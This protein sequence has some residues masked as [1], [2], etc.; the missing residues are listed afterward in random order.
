MAELRGHHLKIF[1]KIM[2]WSECNICITN[3]WWRRLWSCSKKWDFS[4]RNTLFNNWLMFIKNRITIVFLRDSVTGHFLCFQITAA[5]SKLWVQVVTL[6]NYVNYL[7]VMLTTFL[8]C[9]VMA[10]FYFDV[11]Q[12]WRHYP[13]KLIA[14]SSVSRVLFHITNIFVT[15][16]SLVHIFL[17]L[18]LDL[19]AVLMYELSKTISYLEDLKN[20]QYFILI[21]QCN[22]M[23]MNFQQENV[24]LSADLESLLSSERL[25]DMPGFLDSQIRSPVSLPFR[26]LCWIM[27]AFRI[28]LAVTLMT[29]F[30][31]GMYKRLLWR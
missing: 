6:S 13:I 20:F 16:P 31:W 8:V 22:D 30:V 5:Q 28:A 10:I 29:I 26:R 21:T 1:V 11:K 9:S 18:C 3:L 17:V 4:V 2:F 15:G 14:F 19:F 25:F 23:W 24:D 7:T 27:R 12:K